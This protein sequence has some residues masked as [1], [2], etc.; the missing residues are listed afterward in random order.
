MQGGFQ[1]KSNKV[2]SSLMVECPHESHDINYN[3]L[4][5]QH[6]RKIN[7]VIMP[8][9][10]ISPRSHGPS[11]ERRTSHIILSWYLTKEQNK[12]RKCKY[13]MVYS[14]FYMDLNRTH[15]YIDSSRRNETKLIGL[16]FQFPLILKLN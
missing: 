12:R 2:S 11:W 16:K 5:S 14:L 3:F 7:D 1:E 10:L 8:F 4:S 13:P 15:F 9:F 6:I